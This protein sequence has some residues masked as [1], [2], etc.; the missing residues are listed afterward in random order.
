[1]KKIFFLSICYCFALS[2]FGQPSS[3]YPKRYQI[4]SGYLEYQYTGSITGTKTLWFDDYGTKYREETKTSETV[5]TGKKIETI[6]N[7]SLSITDGTYYYNVNLAD[8]KGT[9]IHKNAMPDFSL[10][11]SGLNQSEAEMLGEG[12][13]NSLGGKVE[14][15]QEIFLGKLC[16]VTT[17]LGV[18]VHSYK[19]IA[20]KTQTKINDSEYSE[21]ALHFKE[22]T[23]I[24]ANSFI[25]PNNAIIEDVSADISGNTNFDEDMDDESGLTF[26]SGFDFASFKTESDRIRRT[27]GYGFAMHD[28]SSAQF[29][30]MWT[31]NDNSMIGINVFSLKNY[32]NWQSDFADEGIEYFTHNGEKMA[33]RK[34]NFYDEETGKSK[35]GAFLLIEN[36]PKDAFWQITTS[37][38]KDKNE[39][40]S[41]YKQFKL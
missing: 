21:I 24:P 30:S 32:T 18:T 15:K 35:P 14:K 39:L 6:A 26:T 33:Y 12:I 20:L 29:S 1:M 8:N 40:I 13:V 25:P 22:N 3:N 28:A 34:D 5:K 37:P 36:K 7:H 19:G 38:E 9:K 41:I 11:T 4:K 10:L 23:S 16:D 27:L 17:L 2:L 31:K